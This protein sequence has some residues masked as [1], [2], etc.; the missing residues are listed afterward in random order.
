MKDLNLYKSLLVIMFVSTE[1]KM[2]SLNET[3]D[4]NF[5]NH[6]VG[7]KYIYLGKCGKNKLILKEHRSS[8]FCNRNMQKDFFLFLSQI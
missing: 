6:L 8:S 7:E 1:F 4:F 3:V 2:F 5:K